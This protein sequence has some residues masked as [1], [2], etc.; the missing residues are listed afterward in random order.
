[1]TTRKPVRQ[2]PLP[3]AG[4]R[5]PKPGSSRTRACLRPTVFVRRRLVAASNSAGKPL[6]AFGTRSPGSSCY[7]I[8]AE[9]PEL[10]GGGMTATLG[11]RHAAVSI[12][13]RGRL[14][15]E[16]T[17]AIAGEVR[18]DQGA[19]AVYA[20]DASVYRQV[21][22]GV[23]IPRDAADVVAAVAVCRDHEVPILGRGCGTALA[24][25]SVNAAVVFDFSKYMRD[26]V[27]IDPQARTARVQPG[28]ICDQ[29]RDAAA[30]HGLTFAVDPATHNRCT[31]GG[32]IGNNS[33]GTH[34]VMGGTTADNVLELDVL[35]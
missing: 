8:S 10:Q 12:T 18:F 35:T 14:A 22:I 11:R 33:C 30:E 5:R 24:G 9:R 31:I 16:L 6:A 23:V 4:Y 29:L 20:N 25:Q 13:D 3:R 1:L 34:S 27:R 2:P 7:D 19:L 15:R 32:M 17:E 26:I 21:P 28:V